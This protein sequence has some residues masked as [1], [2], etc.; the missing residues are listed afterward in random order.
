MG[1]F[2]KYLFGFTFL[3]FM[4]LVLLACVIFTL[5]AFGSG[6]PGFGIFCLIVTGCFGTGTFIFTKALFQG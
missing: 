5:G 6:Q 4:W 1:D 2:M 3:L